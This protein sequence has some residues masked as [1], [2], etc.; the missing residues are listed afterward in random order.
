MPLVIEPP[1][2]VPVVPPGAALVDRHTEAPSVV[3][4]RGARHSQLSR[5]LYLAQTLS[6]ERYDGLPRPYP[7]A[8]GVNVNDRTR[9]SFR[10]FCLKPVE[11]IAHG[12]LS[13]SEATRN[14]DRSAALC[15]QLSNEVA[16][17]V[18]EHMF[19]R[20][21]DGK[22]VLRPSVSDYP[23]YSMRGRIRV[24]RLVLAQEIGVQSPRLAVISTAASP[25]TTNSAAQSSISSSRLEPIVPSRHAR[26]S[27]AMPPASR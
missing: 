23:G 10:L 16:G 19:P 12:G 20:P 22:L 21:S 25:A 1:N 24:I 2:G 3:P 14:L 13:K 18:H 15:V 8:D 6:Q 17:A 9:D 26:S 7:Q 11:V 4:D 5:D 27:S